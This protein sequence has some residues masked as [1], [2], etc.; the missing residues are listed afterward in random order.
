MSKPSCDGWWIS[1]WDFAAMRVTMKWIG[2]S[3]G[4]YP[5]RQPMPRHWPKGSMSSFRLFSYSQKNDE[6]APFGFNCIRYSMSGEPMSHVHVSDIHHIEK[7]FF[8]WFKG[9]VTD[10]LW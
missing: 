8:T 6:T 9:N 5:Y 7:H 4:A 10:E 1:C 3:W 2:D